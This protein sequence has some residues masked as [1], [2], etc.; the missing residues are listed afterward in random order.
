MTRVLDIDD[1]E[2]SIPSCAFSPDGSILLVG[3]S[4]GRLLGFSLDSSPHKVPLFLE[5]NAHDLGVSTVAFSSSNSI[6]ASSKD[7]DGAKKTF[8]AAT[9][10]VDS[11]VRLW[12]IQG[13]HKSALVPVK[14]P[15]GMLTGHSS[16]V[17][18][19]KFHPRGRLLASASGDKT[20]RLWNTEIGL[21]VA[22]LQGHERYVTSVSFSHNG[23][24]LASGSNDRSVILWQ[25]EPAE[26]SNFA[27]PDL[28][29][30]EVLVDIYSA[31]AMR[32]SQ[33]ASSWAIS[34]VLEWLEDLGLNQY[35]D[36]FKMN[37]IDGPA[38]LKLHDSKLQELSIGLI[39]HVE[40]GHRLRI[41]QECRHLAEDSHLHK[42]DKGFVP[43]EF[44][45]P[46]T[47]TIMMDPVVAADGFSY[48]RG[49]IQE[50]FSRSPT[51]PLTNERVIHTMLIPN[52]T[53][54][55]LIKRHLASI[56]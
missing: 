7:G 51:S 16:T 34:D 30:G 12:H 9:G 54:R 45:C 28:K 37:Q 53:L 20:V 44:Y 17:M 52:R 27:P 41:L 23:Q 14:S 47:H 35:R 32:L 19:V 22:V 24:Y 5:K 50:W 11:L 18:S 3:T 2:A 43:I 38:L 8:L 25:I 6:S 4:T 10:G 42:M 46:I 29:N 49:A 13:N 21:C 48:E 1:V 15:H 31:P 36:T 55:V 33:P 26:T 39:S 56:I 40:K